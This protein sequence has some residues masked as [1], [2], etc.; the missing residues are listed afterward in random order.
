VCPDTITHDWATARLRDNITKTTAT[1]LPKTCS[2]SGS[3]TQ[4]SGPVTAGHGYTLTLTSHDDNKVG[5]ATYTLYDD[6]TI[7]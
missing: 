4:A 2:N 5:D 3:W 1:I 6:V 7:A